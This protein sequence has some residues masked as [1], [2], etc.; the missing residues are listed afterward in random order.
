MLH[1]SCGCSPV[2]LAIDNHLILL[3]RSEP[4][5]AHFKKMDLK[6]HMGD[7]SHFI[8][9]Y[10][11]L[12]VVTYGGIITAR[13]SSVITVS[14]IFP[15]HGIF[16]FKILGQNSMLSF[17]MTKPLLSSHAVYNIALANQPHP[18]YIS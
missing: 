12:K 5:I 18:A 1:W 9:I 4:R 13:F 6:T 17:Q 10:F 11:P 8:C 7:Y 15:P 2:R 16:I 14:N 3:L